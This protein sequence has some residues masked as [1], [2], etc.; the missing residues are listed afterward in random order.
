MAKA[1]AQKKTV[2][3][4]LR[5]KAYHDLKTLILTGQLRPSERLSES[6]LAE[7]LGVS[8]TP[9]REALM[10]LEEEGLVVG[11][12][13]LGYVVTDL[14]VTAV[15]DLLI[16]RQALDAC[17]AE[18]ACARA[19]EEDFERIRAIIRQ[20]VELRD[21]KQDIPASAAQGLDLGLEIH[22]VIAQATRNEALIRAT[23]QIYQQLQLALWLEVLLV[24]FGDSDLAEH[25]AIADAILARDPSGAAEA[26][27]V[28]VQG[29]L[30]NMT[31]VQDILRHRQGLPR[32]AL[33]R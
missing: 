26:A 10:K 13:N 29:S 24:D 4:S 16:V 17:A 33:P 25:K 9:L 12:R 18:L 21:P 2:Q 7:R 22:K 30:R 6:R 3:Y 5:E 15:C 32:F 23:D 27:R 31:K 1:V 14:D 11:Q 8:R 28:H 20:M 19:T